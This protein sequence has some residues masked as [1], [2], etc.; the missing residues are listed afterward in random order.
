MLTSSDTSTTTI[1]NTNTIPNTTISNTTIPNTTISNTTN[2]NTTN[3]DNVELT[4]H[5][6]K[7]FTNAHTNIFQ[8]DFNGTSNIYSPYIY[9]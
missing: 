6:Y 8:R 7:I 3:T 4:D 1:P 9:Y 5:G 2:P